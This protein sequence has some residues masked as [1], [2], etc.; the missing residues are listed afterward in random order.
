MSY[1][2]KKDNLS[3]IVKQWN[4]RKFTLGDLA[5]EIGV[6]TTTI[7]NRLK[8]A[9]KQGL[10][11][12]KGSQGKAV[13]DS[14]KVTILN[15]IKNTIENVSELDKFYQNRILKFRMEG[16]ASKDIANRLGA[17]QSKIERLT[18]NM[19]IQGIYVPHY[20]NITNKYSLQDEIDIANQIEKYFNKDLTLSEIS[21]LIGISR[22]KTT[23]IIYKH[24]ISIINYT[25]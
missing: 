16:L 2:I 11:V 20:K 13:K 17:S 1:R 21:S 25:L 9:R 7:A 15:H 10:K 3:Y 8:K 12:A 6:S 14:S 22:A 23:N 18:A 5:K 4:T 24:F 19:D